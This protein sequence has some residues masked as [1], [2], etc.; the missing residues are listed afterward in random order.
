[1]LEWEYCD[2]LLG[3][4][5]VPARQRAV[6]AEIGRLPN[7]D[8]VEG[9]DCDKQGNQPAAHQRDSALSGKSSFR[10]GSTNPLLAS[11]RQGWVSHF[12]IVKIYEADLDA[13]FHF[14]FANLV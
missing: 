5:G 8:P 9:K 1:M 13:V 6:P 11:I 12:V 2:P 14:T 10:H 3:N 4:D 7:G